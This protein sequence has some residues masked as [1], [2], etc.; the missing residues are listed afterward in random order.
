MLQH[1]SASMATGFTTAALVRKGDI[2]AAD[3]E[4][5]LGGRIDL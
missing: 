4:D 1:G 5:G 3:G 2:L